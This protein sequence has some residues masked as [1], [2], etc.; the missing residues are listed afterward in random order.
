MHRSF[1]S[2]LQALLAAA[3]LAAPRIVHACSVCTGGQK[4]EV[5]QA[6]LIGSLFLSVLPL[7]AI[8]AVVWWLRRRSR[9]LD[10]GARM[11][12]ASSR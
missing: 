6:F 7:A 8:G 10:N 12:S 4:E 2:A 3:L 9:A 11:L 5:N 1:R